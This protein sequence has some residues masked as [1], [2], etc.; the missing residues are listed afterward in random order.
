MR[1]DAPP[2]RQS[3]ADGNRG[4]FARQFGGMDTAKRQ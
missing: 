1:D 4:W 3:R 2:L